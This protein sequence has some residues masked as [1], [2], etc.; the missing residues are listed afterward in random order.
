[1]AEKKSVENKDKKYKKERITIALIIS[2]FLSNFHRE[3]FLGVTDF[4]KTAD[5]NLVT[6]TSGS[7]KTPS[8]IA[9]MRNELYDLINPEIYDGLLVPIGS[10]SRFVPIENFIEQLNKYSPLPIVNL[11]SKVN[12][13][14]SVMPDYKTGMRELV[15]HLIKKHKCKNNYLNNNGSLSR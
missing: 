9:L 3:M 8:K 5:I 11:G 4:V 2:S 12:D 6:L 7:F 1:L 10:L 13:Y 15:N 14:Y